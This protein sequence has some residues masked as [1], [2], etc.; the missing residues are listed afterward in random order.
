LLRYGSKFL[1]SNFSLATHFSSGE[2]TRASKPRPFAIFY[3]FILN[4]F[5]VELDL[6]IDYDW[7]SKV[8]LP[9]V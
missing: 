1:P 2:A 8:L 7:F 4:N 9:I 3:K 6:R 5:S